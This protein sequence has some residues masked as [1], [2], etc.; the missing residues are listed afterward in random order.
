MAP[1]AA[2]ETVRK[3]ENLALRDA[4]SGEGVANTP[5]RV[6]PKL[7]DGRI[8]GKQL[9]EWFP[10][11]RKPVPRARFGRSSAISE[12]RIKSENSV[13]LTVAGTNRGAEI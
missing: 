3:S 7:I 13:G 12:K 4:F 1:D 5:R 11:P 10:R 2:S 8:F 9:S 6:I